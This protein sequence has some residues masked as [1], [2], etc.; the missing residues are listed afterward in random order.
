MNIISPSYVIGRNG[1]VAKLASFD[2]NK[3]REIMS[4]LYLNYTVKTM[5]NGKKGIIK[6]QLPLFTIENGYIKIM[7]FKAFEL[8][9]QGILPR[10]PLCCIARGDDVGAFNTLSLYP[11]QQCIVD[12]LFTHIYTPQKIDE[13]SAGVILELEAGLGKTYVAG[14]VIARYKKKTLVIVPN[15][16]LMNQ[17]YKVFAQIGRVGRYYGREKHDGDIVIMIVNS[18]LS[19]SFIFAGSQITPAEYFKKFDMV[20]LD[21][22]NEYCSAERSKIYTRIQA[23]CMLGITAEANARDDNLD[24]LTH[25]NVGPVLCAENIPN[26]DVPLTDKYNSVVHIVKY[27]GANEYTRVSYNS[28]GCVNTAELIDLLLQDPNRMDLIITYAKWLWNKGHNF[29]I[30]CD[31]R[32]G[33]K[34]IA[35]E[36]RNIPDMCGIKEENVAPA[37]LMGGAT[38]EDVQNA[39][40][41]RIIVATYQ[42]AYRGVSL[43]KFDAMIFATPRRAKIYQTL[44]RIYRMSGDT[45]I[46]RHI[47]DIV[48]VNTCLRAQLAERMQQY[49]NPIFGMKIE[50]IKQ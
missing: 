36:L 4:C 49:K 6:K 17:N 24:K 19:D 41:A 26:F 44:K 43:P 10:A 2:S 25:Y 8:V 46:T 18:V 12:Y 21:E 38:D 28:A 23:R 11:Y 13:G 34:L 40:T 16:Y 48:D 3:I 33:V 27:K 9:E 32:E 45:S 15:V 30:W 47:V 31:R 50:N 20:I 22:V 39:E 7:R 42:Y 5:I 14:A 37:I 29:F 1:Y 35:Q